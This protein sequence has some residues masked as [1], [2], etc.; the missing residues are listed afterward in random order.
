M[1]ESQGGREVSNTLPTFR[2]PSLR[3]PAAAIMRSPDHPSGTATPPIQTPASV[4]FKWEEEPGKPRPCSDIIIHPSAAKILELPPCRVQ[5]QLCADKINSQTPSPTTVLDGPYINVGR[6]KF[7]SF[8]FFREAHDLF[9]GGSSSSSGSGA[10]P[11]GGGVDALFL[12]GRSGV[13][14]KQRGIFGKLKRRKK[15]V[16]AGSFRFSSSSTP[17]SYYECDSCDENCNEENR[18]EGNMRM[19]GSLFNVSQPRN[20]HLWATIYEGLKQVMPWKSSRKSKKE[21]PV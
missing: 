13:W 16:G 17:C 7:S 21:G 19:K 14:Q 6:P 15:D 3:I 20:N 8:R 12:G 10:S 11:L 5:R 2:L 9:D 4:P 18:R 1:E